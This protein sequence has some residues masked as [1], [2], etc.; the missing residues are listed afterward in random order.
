LKKKISRLKLFLPAPTKMESDIT[1]IS[2]SLR[3]LQLVLF[4]C[5][6]TWFASIIAVVAPWHTA[7]KLLRGLGAKAISYDPM[8]DYWL[9][10]ATGAF[11]LVG[12]LFIVFAL[13]P[14]RYRNVIPLFGWLMVVEGLVLFFHGLRLNLPPL[15]FYADTAACLL[16]GAGILGLSRRAFRT[17]G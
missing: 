4:F 2:R 16:G 9:R 11:S 8:L 12:T 5:G 3:H 13:R 10:M 17:G 7:E 6:L 14:E 15:P 1:R